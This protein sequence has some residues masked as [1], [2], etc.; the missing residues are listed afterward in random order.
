MN[1]CLLDMLDYDILILSCTH[2]HSHSHTV[3]QKEK[4][5]SGNLI[6]NRRRVIRFYNLESVCVVLCINLYMSVY[7]SSVGSRFAHMYDSIES[8]DFFFN[9]SI[10]LLHYKMRR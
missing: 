8:C 1:V 6:A 2:S 4:D 10:I 9:I 7:D 5:I 3:H